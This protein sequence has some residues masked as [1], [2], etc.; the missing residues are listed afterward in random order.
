MLVQRLAKNILALFLPIV[1][2]FSYMPTAGANINKKPRAN[3]SSYSIWERIAAEAELNHLHKHPHVKHYITKYSKDIVHINSI[4]THAEPYLYYIIEELEK[5]G[6][7]VELALLPMVESAY[8]PFAISNAD[9]AGIWQIQSYTG[10]FYDLYQD[11]WYDGRKD[12][13]KATNAAL[14]H[15]QALHKRFAGDWALA[16]AGYNAGG[17]RVNQC[18]NKN[19]KKGHATDYWSLSLPKETMDFVPKFL[20][21][22]HIIQHHERYNLKLPQISN[23]PYFATLNINEQIDLHAAANLADITFEEIRRLNPAYKT[24]YTRPQKIDTILLPIQKINSFRQALNNPATSKIKRVK[25]ITEHEKFHT[26][27]IG[28]TLCI[29]AKKYN[30]TIDAIVTNNQLKSAHIIFDGQRIKVSN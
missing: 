21:I 11:K 5:K 7:P 15:L 27:K 28:E 24:N 12:I 23:K 20:A 17:G 16:L 4:T 25:S 6:M 9:A 30:T 19:I 10:Q 29:I 13:K 18:I 26:V 14:K 3:I 1:I 22:S 8:K 2:F